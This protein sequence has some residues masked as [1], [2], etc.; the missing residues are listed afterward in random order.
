MNQPFRGDHYFLPVSPTK[1]L[2]SLSKFAMM[3]DHDMLILGPLFQR[4]YEENRPRH[5]DTIIHGA[6]SYNDAYLFNSLSTGDVRIRQYT[7]SYLFTSQHLGAKAIEQAH[8]QDKRLSPLDD[9]F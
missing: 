9:L 8:K 5:D 3:S 7:V 4:L 1:K 6:L 2:I